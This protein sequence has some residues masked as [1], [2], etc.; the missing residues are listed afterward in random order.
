MCSCLLRHGLIWTNTL[1]SRW[2]LN[3]IT[4]TLQRFFCLG[5]QC[6]YPRL[7]CSRLAHIPK[8][9]QHHQHYYETLAILIEFFFSYVAGKLSLLYIWWILWRLYILLR[10]F[11]SY[12]K[13]A[14][15]Q[16]VPERGSS[17]RIASRGE[18]LLRQVVLGPLKAPRS[19]SLI[20][21]WRC[22]RYAVCRS[23]WSPYH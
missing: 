6:Q 4:C 16:E 7:G 1:I 20:H 21:I 3:T 17:T 8:T 15:R 5:G 14:H 10:Q 13:Q 18:E 9:F 22:R 2:G 23:R 12:G 19:L 11:C